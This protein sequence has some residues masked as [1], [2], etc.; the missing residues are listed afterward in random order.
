MYGTR[1]GDRNLSRGAVSLTST[2]QRKR[3]SSK[4]K[5]RHY[6]KSVDINLHLLLMTLA[7][8]E[9]VRTGNLPKGNF[10]MR[11]REAF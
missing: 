4:S 3:I 5:Y 8:V 2:D 7:K 9:V 11:Q 1:L 10:G 6:R